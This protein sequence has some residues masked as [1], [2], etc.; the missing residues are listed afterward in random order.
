[1]SA[2][3]IGGSHKLLFQTQ[4]IL[5]LFIF[6]LLAACQSGSSSNKDEQAWKAL[7]QAAVEG[8]DQGNYVDALPK[9]QLAYEYANETFGQDHPLTLVSLNQLALWYSRNGQLGKAENLYAKTLEARERILGPRSPATLQSMNNLGL[10]YNKTGLHDKARPL[11]EQAWQGH[12]EVHG[13]SHGDTLN[14]LHNLAS[15]YIHQKNYDDAASLYQEI[16]NLGAGSID[17]NDPRVLSTK[18]SLA[19]AYVGQR[20]YEEAEELH[21]DVLDR[22]RRRLGKDHPDTLHSMG[23]LAGVYHR[24]GRHEEALTLFEETIAL[25]RQVLGLY[26]PLTLSGELS[27]V[28]P[29]IKLGKLDE[30]VARLTKAS[31]KRRQYAKGELA[32]T[33]SAAARAAVLKRQRAFQN[34]VISLSMEVPTTKTII[35][36]ARVM[37]DWKRIQ[38]PEAAY[39][40]HLVRSAEDQNVRQLA[41][42]IKT[43]RTRLSALA[44]TRHKQDKLMA[45]VEELE[46]KEFALANINERFQQP[47]ASLDQLAKALPR[48]TAVVEF[49]Q[50]QYVDFETGFEFGDAEDGHFAAL[51]IRPGREPTIVGTEK[52]SVLSTHLATIHSDHSSKRSDG[53]AAA[54]FRQL[55]SG[56][57]DDLEGIKEL[58]I[59]PDGLLHLVP[60]DRLILPDGGY[61]GEKMAI[62][63]IP[64]GRDLLIS[65]PSKR[66][67][68]LL[69]IGGVD[70]D[71]AHQDATVASTVAIQPDG[72]NALSIDE[73]DIESVRGEVSSVFSEFDPLPASKDEVQ[74]VA[75]VYSEK[76][77]EDPIH[78]WIGSSASEARLK[79]LYGLNEAPRVLHIAT[80][81]F[82]L[83]D[84]IQNL[85]RP[86]LYS[87]LVL[88]GANRSFAEQTSGATTT[89]EDGILYSIEAQDLDLDGTE[90]VVLSACDTAKGVIDY[91]EGIVGMVEALRIAGAKKILTT[92]WPV[93]DKPT[94]AFMQILYENWMNDP[95]N[96]VAGA[97]DRTKSMFRQHQN[98]DYRSPMVWAPFVLIES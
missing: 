6:G 23:N 94:A 3:G 77:P 68:G 15:L 97:L 74:R 39:L 92:L 64:T 78:V 1:M 34:A 7:H 47:S 17:E 70:F 90:L 57:A 14:S 20:R 16:L 26:H 4:R 41:L 86:N 35:A 71:D 55:F 88:A 2:S 27:S 31:D 44:Q 8:F 36:A 28:Y 91:S 84:S 37:L 9:A 62:R 61:W 40:A 75:K 60:F 33:R 58:Y 85:S 18:R 89:S 73:A 79:G 29:L 24:Q 80:H 22:R 50:F 95:E 72:L 82:Y 32:S 21:Q 19:T 93:L 45:I 63:I 53:A 46:A 54:L 38:G 49:R 30:A 43:L 96:D 83:P 42:D 13:V 51:L 12:R 5:V 52:I 11:L 87:G 98:P 10:L 25:R 56:L 67:V 59:A 76:R 66:G 48:N 81:G 65:E 69:A